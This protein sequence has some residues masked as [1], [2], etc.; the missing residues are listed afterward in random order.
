MAPV[1]PYSHKRE[2]TAAEIRITRLIEAGI[3]RAKTR[4]R[5][6]DR[7]TARQ[8]A[9]CLHHGLGG[10]LAIFAGTGR[11]AHPQAARLELFYATRDEPNLTAWGQALRPYITWQAHHHD[12]PDGDHPSTGHPS[13]GPVTPPAAP[14]SRDPQAA[15]V[16]LRTSSSDP[17]SR[18]GLALQ[19]QY[20]ACRQYARRCLHRRLGGMFA[21]RPGSHGSGIARLLA[22][23]ALCHSQRV[24][25][26][27]LDRL[28]PGS[29]GACRVAALGARLLSVT[30]QHTRRLNQQTDFN[31]DIQHLD[32]SKGESQ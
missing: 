12:Q 20:W 24:V 19:M 26:H 18:P 11:L 14:V 29:D 31:Q 4:H 32:E 22:H 17:V 1:H 28:P 25:V 9:A 8:I 3:N 13:T 2:K 30:D 5:L 6:I 27:R 16:Y 15:V 21:D 10:E 23:L 7:D